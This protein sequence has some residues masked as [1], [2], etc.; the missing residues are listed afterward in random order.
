MK[1][2]FIFILVAQ[3]LLILVTLT[4]AFVQQGI[5]RENANLAEYNALRAIEQTKLAHENAVMYN[6]VRTE[7]EKCK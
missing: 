1:K 3:A 7:L 5:A 2:K 4:Y 6:K